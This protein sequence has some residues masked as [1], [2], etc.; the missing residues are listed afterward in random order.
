[1]L[2]RPLHLF[3]KDIVQTLEPRIQYVRTPY[4][5]QSN[6]PLFD[7]APRDFN[8]YAIFSENAFTGVDRIS[9]ANQVTMGLTTRLLD[10][11]TGA[12]AMRLGV[13]QK[14]L[15]ADQRVNPDGPDPITQRLSDLLLLGSTSVIPNWNI[16]GTMQ[17]NAQNHAAERGVM[18]VR[19]SPGAWR[20]V[21]VSY[22]YTRNASE[23]LD[24]GWQ[25]PI[26]G[27]IPPVEAVR[28]AAVSDPMNLSNTRRANTGACGGTW[29]SV[30]RMSYSMLD[31]R[32]T[33]SLLGM[34]YDAGCWVGRVIAERVSV[35]RA[36]AS[37]RVMFQLELVGLSR[38]SLGSNPLRALKDNVPG[39]R[40]LHDDGAAAP[41]TS[42]MPL[43][44]DD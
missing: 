10:A 42:S 33:S 4:K 1:V 25:W 38:V 9:D 6:L 35:G 31:K 28:D 18:G 21:G 22:N 20:T 37:T 29:Y 24:V 27:P 14:L 8:Q 40:L 16:D 11:A 36:Q 7:S 44:T 13:V 43:T 26:A 19:Y 3:D 2:E 34:E 12:E 41:T 32:L 5:D 17:F 39:Y 15:L 30:G 23:Q